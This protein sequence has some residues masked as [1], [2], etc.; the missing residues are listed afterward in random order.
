M[1]DQ[2]N[3]SAAPDNQNDAAPPASLPEPLPLLEALPPPDSPAST[4]SPPK[5]S[6]NK[7]LL[8]IGAFAVIAVIVLGVWVLLA[9]NAIRNTVE[10][11]SQTIPLVSQESLSNQIA[12]VGNDFNLWLVSPDGGN[13]RRLTLDGNGY[14]FPTWSPDGQQLAFI[15]RT[16]SN[17]SVLYVSPTDHA[18]PRI[19][20]SEPASP[21]FYLYWSPDSRYLTFLTQ[22][23]TD[24]AMRIVGTAT[25][26]APRILE[27]GAP[28]YWAWSPRS[29]RLLMHVGGSRATS[30]QAH[31][32]LLG[33]QLNAQREPLDESPGRF[34]APLW[35]ADGSHVFYIAENNAGGES[36]YRAEANTLAPQEIIEL[37]NF[38]QM[39]LSPDDRHLAFLQYE[40]GTQ[41]PF[42]RAYLVD[43]AGQQ[44][45]RLTNA[46]VASMYWSPDGKKLALLTLNRPN[47]G[48]TARAAGLAAPLPQEFSLRWWVYTLE[49]DELTPLVSFEPTLNF[50][51]TVPYFDQYHLSLRFWSPDSRYLVVTKK[52]AQGSSAGSVWVVDTTGQEEPRKVG[53]GSLAVWS[54]Q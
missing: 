33:S 9:F 42:G 49:T 13:L 16:D 47:E 32:S 27:R 44:S 41:P 22:E 20:Y 48:P 12:F 29:D 35:S 24:I 37:N 46:L 50:L 5:R 18:D 3:E 21:P 17:S 54:W 25:P 40:D 53:D 51:Q 1:N 23:E 11:T 38:A 6:T 19:V 30:G 52:L 45:R 36:I 43:V 31:I 10:R 7:F 39:V 8:A 26:V 34:Q 2:P 14:R 4:L 15:G 28:F